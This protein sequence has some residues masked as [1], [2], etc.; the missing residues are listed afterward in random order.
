MQ[1]PHSAMCYPPN[2]MVLIS[3]KKC[4]NIVYSLDWGKPDFHLIKHITLARLPG[5]CAGFYLYKCSRI[6][7]EKIKSYQLMIHPIN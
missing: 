2:R 7:D 4:P 3:D 1:Q 5:F 6:H